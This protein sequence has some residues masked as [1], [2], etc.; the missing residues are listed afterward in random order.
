MSDEIEDLFGH[1][2]PGI[3]YFIAFITSPTCNPERLF[4]F[5]LFENTEAEID[6]IK[7]RVKHESEEQEHRERLSKELFDVLKD[8]DNDVV[9]EFVKLSSQSFVMQKN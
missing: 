7:T 1:F 8:H 5:M 2:Y 3:A 9:R 6:F 4:E